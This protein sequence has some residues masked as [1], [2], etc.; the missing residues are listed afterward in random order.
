VFESFNGDC[1]SCQIRFFDFL[2][3][4]QLKIVTVSLL[5]II[6]PTA[7][8]EDER[9]FVRH[10]GQEWTT[11]KRLAAY[12]HNPLEEEAPR[13]L[14]IGTEPEFAIGPRALFLQSDGGNLLWV[15]SRFSTARRLRIRFWE[16]TTL[17]LW[18]GL[19]LIN[20]GGHFEGGSGRP[21]SNVFSKGSNHSHSNKFTAR[22]GK[23]T[24]SQMQKRRCAVQPNGTSTPSVSKCA[25]KLP[26]ATRGR[27][28]HSE[29][30][31][32]RGTKPSRLR[33]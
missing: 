22:G 25:V 15:A 11:L 10:G 32:T 19:T 21:R 26:K 27:A 12:H 18:D 33:V 2:A 8:S 29:S 3:K 13:L 31:A 1:E 28:K 16:E 6:Q 20:C 14:G 30:A 4:W 23:R 17:S 7:A 9:Q 24:F 5:L